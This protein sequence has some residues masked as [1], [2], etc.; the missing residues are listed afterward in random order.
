V[1][2]SSVGTA[3]VVRERTNRDAEALSRQVD[4]QCDARCSPDQ[5]REL[6]LEALDA[7][8]DRRNRYWVSSAIAG[9]VLTVLGVSLVILNRATN[10]RPPVA[11]GVTGA[12]DRVAITLRA[13]F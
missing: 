10:E 1:A 13:A 4:D 6:G 7:Q 12:Q 9:G 11:V 2:S 5:Y 3:V 8:I